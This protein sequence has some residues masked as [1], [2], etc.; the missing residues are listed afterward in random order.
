MIIEQL[1]SKQI[2]S[3]GLD[4]T[5]RTIKKI[6]DNAKFH[7]LLVVEKGVL[8]GVISD[9]DL[10][11][12][13]S[14][15]IGTSKETINDTLTLNQKVHQIMTRKLIT[16]PFTAN[17]YDAI[18]IFNQHSISCIPIVNESKQAVGI[19]SWRDILRAIEA[20]RNKKA[21]GKLK[22]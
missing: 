1:M 10:L 22:S 15:H 19:V 14:P 6:F 8:Y 12:A 3:V 18:H 20:N 16:L 17:V 21:A 9:R 2:V 5:L 4:E 7:H 13:I 11:K